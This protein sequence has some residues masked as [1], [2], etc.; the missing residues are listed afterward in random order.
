MRSV[1]FK[2]EEELVKA[3]VV[4][5]R[6]AGRRDYR[7]ELEVDAGV[8]IADVVLAKR[9]V[10]TTKALQVLAGITPRLAV[11]LSPEVCR[12]ITSRESLAAALGTTEGGTARVIALLSNLGLVQKQADNLFISPI[13]TTP[14]ERVIAVEAKLSEWQR[15]LVQAYRNL[16]FADESWVVL[17]HT[18]VRPALSQLDS[19]KAA[20]V[21]LASLE[22]GRG[23]YIHQAAETIGPM[24]SAKH[25][26]AQAV[27]ASRVVARRQ[28]LESL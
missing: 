22:R 15:V 25:W 26:Q 9:T 17:D 4:C 27:L 6:R 23:L 20:G 10:R 12:S 19:F 21:G 13:T 11:L 2:S 24:S 8:G 7:V 3:I 5:A 1:A 16:Q 18:Y 28:P 14:F